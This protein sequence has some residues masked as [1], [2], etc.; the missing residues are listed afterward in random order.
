MIAITPANR[1][2]L[3]AITRLLTEAHLPLDGL[4]PWLHQIVVATEDNQ[5]VGCVALEIYGTVALLRSVA[6]ASSHQG[7]QVG[8]RLVDAVLA[9][10]RE[11]GIHD[12]Y[13]LTETASSYFS[14]WG[15]TSITRD[16]VAP[17]LQRSVEWREACPASALV[18]RLPLTA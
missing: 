16:D 5:I 6:V 3:P 17:A 14:R 11:Q 9:Q 15:F 4:T 13:L 8:H 18:M 12:L 1:E 2:D 10:A 7:Q